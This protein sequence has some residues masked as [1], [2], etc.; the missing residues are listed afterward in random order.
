MKT[1]LVGSGYWG[2]H[3]ARILSELTELRYIVDLNPAVLPK[4]PNTTCTSSLDEALDSDTEVV[5]LVTPASTHYAL[6][7]QA[8]LANK[9]VFSEKPF[10]VVPEHGDELVQLAHE[11]NLRLMTGFT[12]LFVPS[13]LRAKEL[14]KT[15]TTYYLTSR[16]TN[17]GP[18]RNDVSVVWD[19]VPHDVAMFLYWMESPVVS[20]SAV[21]STFLS[22]KTDAVQVTL[23]FANG[24]IGSIFASWAEPRKVREFAV[25]GSKQTLVL[26][27]VDVKAPLTIYHKGVNVNDILTPTQEFG[28]FKLIT[29]SGSLEVPELPIA[30]PLK[31]EIVHFLSCVNNPDMVCVSDGVLGTSVTKILHAIEESILKHGQPVYLQ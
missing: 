19:L 18:I 10:V 23:R 26:D 2:K 22:S 29:K 28:S 11:R 4:Y 30:E 3:Y 5:F 1:V 27:D 20:V 31:T 25:V 7:K 8:L 16:R 15:G 6:A 24:V 14:M 12:F 17:M 21:G 13:V 9:H